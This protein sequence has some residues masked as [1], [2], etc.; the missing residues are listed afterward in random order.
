MLWV[1]FFFFFVRSMFSGNRDIM[2]R[3]GGALD[4]HPS[5][6]L[7]SRRGAYEREGGNVRTTT[8]RRQFGCDNEYGKRRRLRHSNKS[9]K[10]QKQNKTRTVECTRRPPAR[11]L[12]RGAGET[13][14]LIRNRTRAQ[15]T[16][17]LLSEKPITFFVSCVIE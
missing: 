1:V 6:S 15:A 17:D 12:A 7:R 4:H 13:T 9:R 5:I 3:G 8:G 16:D 11:S 2:F 10:R 14:E